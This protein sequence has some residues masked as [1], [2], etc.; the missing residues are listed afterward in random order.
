MHGAGRDGLQAGI[1]F[2]VAVTM[3]WPGVSLADEVWP[4]FNSF[5]P[6]D[7]IRIQ[8]GAQFRLDAAVH[9]SR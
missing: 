5:S 4:E 1:L 6:D 7:G 8:P 3:T 2:A 9:D